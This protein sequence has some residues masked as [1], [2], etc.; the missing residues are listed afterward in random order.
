MILSATQRAHRASRER[1]T[2]LRNRCALAGIPADMIRMTPNRM[3]ATLLEDWTSLTPL[4]V[5]DVDSHGT[6]AVVLRFPVAPRWVTN[7]LTP[8]GAA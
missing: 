1:Y 6:D 2:V 8:G 5:D 4:L 7:S 3:L